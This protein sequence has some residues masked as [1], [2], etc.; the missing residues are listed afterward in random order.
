MLIYLRQD[1]GLLVYGFLWDLSLQSRLRVEHD[2]RSVWQHMRDALKRAKE[3][4]VETRG[5]MKNGLQNLS[6]EAGK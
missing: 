2:Q 5:K 3:A 1:Q 4:K 6:V